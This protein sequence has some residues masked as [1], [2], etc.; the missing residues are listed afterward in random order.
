[1]YFNHYP[2]KLY[3]VIF[4][5][6]IDNKTSTQGCAQGYLTNEWQIQNSAFR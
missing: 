2:T 3:N 5:H 4:S 1:M 6:F